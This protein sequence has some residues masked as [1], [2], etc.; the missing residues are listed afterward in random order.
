MDK[1]NLDLESLLATKD[2]GYYYLNDM[3]NEYNN[4]INSTRSILSQI[5]NLYRTKTENIDDICRILISKHCATSQEPITQDFAKINNAE[6]VDVG[7]KTMT[8]MLTNRV[9]IINQI[10]TI[11]K[12]KE[13]DFDKLNLIMK[14]LL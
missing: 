3:L 14:C 2:L 4:L 12:S 7:I 13:S 10:T 5:T 1:S 11:I 8:H 6:A 9:T